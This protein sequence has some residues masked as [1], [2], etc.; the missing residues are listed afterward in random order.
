MMTQAEHGV[1]ELA[2]QVAMKFS[3]LEALH[4]ADI[5]DVV[6]HVHAI[7]NI[8]MARCAQRDYPNLYP[9]YRNY[10]HKAVKVK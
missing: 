7:Q 3:L 6:F 10:E 5:D 9:T 8:V 1:I 4:P 2:A